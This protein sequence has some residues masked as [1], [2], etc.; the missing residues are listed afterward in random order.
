MIMMIKLISVS[1]RR[2]CRSLQVFVL[3]CAQLKREKNQPTPNTAATRS[4]D[5]TET[6]LKSH[7]TTRQKESRRFSIKTAPACLAMLTYFLTIS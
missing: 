1:S 2:L 6:P 5:F 4:S 3:F 7:T